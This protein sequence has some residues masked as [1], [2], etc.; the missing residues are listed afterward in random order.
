[1]GLSMKM[2]VD[3]VSKR[4]ICDVE[5]VKKWLIFDEDDDENEDDEYNDDEKEDEDVEMLV[6]EENK[7]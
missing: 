4:N 5:F 1:M 2:L 6:S 7:N 3:V